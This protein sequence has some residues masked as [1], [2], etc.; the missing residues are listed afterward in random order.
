MMDSPIYL[1]NN[2]TTAVDP[3]VLEAMLPYL[4]DQYGNA[5]SLTHS[6]G[7]TASAAVEKSRSQV[8]RYL[9]APESD[10]LLFTAG[11]TESINTVLQGVFT[12]YQRKGRHFIT[13]KTEHKAVLDTF[14]YLEKQGADV[15]YLE[16]DGSGQ[17]DLRQLEAAIRPDTVLIALMS[18]N[19][20]TGVLHPLNEISEVAQKHDVLFFCDATQSI[21]KQKIDLM[22]T[23][24]DILC[25]SA[26]KFHG[27]KG[28][29]ALYIR[30]KNKRIQIGSL[31]HGGNQEFGLRAGTLNV[32]AIVGMG[33]AA[34]L[35]YEKLDSDPQRLG[36]L[37]D[38]LER[39]I[40]QLPQTFVNGASSPRLSH[41]TNIT[42]RHLRAAT[43]I[44]KVPH[45]CLSTGSAC[46]SGTRDPSHVLSAMGLEP[47]DAFC[48]IRLSLGR[49]NTE[50][51]IQQAGTLL[52][53]AVDR[54]RRESPNW[55]LF[56]K[57]LI[58]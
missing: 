25:L 44:P 39:R 55:L 8:K 18:A 16:V 26:H 31:L 58:Q 23:P 46:V 42:I 50:Q 5:S 15:S 54:L 6:L 2:A 20:E 10:T 3:Q 19:N 57:G 7:R 28:A 37:R 27:P 21:G 35:A 33:Q 49:F 34:E 51:D 36:R 9:H 40:L 43:L 32:P 30:K 53:E 45:L 22:Q 38:Q 11:A 29:G 17:L 4:K 14:A 52:Y 48:T 13:C 12:H 24:V 56:E 41:V 1:D 47:E